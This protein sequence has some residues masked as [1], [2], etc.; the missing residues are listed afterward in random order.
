MNNAVKIRY[1]LKGDV[2]FTICTVTR[3][4]YEN[5]RVLPIMDVCEILEREVSI[6]SDEIEQMNQKLADVIKN[7]KFE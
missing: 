6:F 5:F 7:D 3:I 4:Q 2:K 1:K